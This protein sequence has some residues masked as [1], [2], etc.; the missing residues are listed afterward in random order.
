M[1]SILLA[2]LS[3][4]AS[5][6]TGILEYRQSR[7]IP[8]IAWQSLLKTSGFSVVRDPDELA[9]LFKSGFPDG[10]DR[11]RVNS[12]RTAVILPPESPGEGAGL[13][14]RAQVPRV[15][16]ERWTALPPSLEGFEEFLR[17]AKEWGEAKT[18]SG[19]APP[20]AR[21]PAPGVR[22][23]GPKWID[24]RAFHY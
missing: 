4:D 22:A 21:A 18:L 10:E 9:Q 19:A 14:A 1:I 8:S 24:P 2:A 3:V 6:K 13:W 5:R 15:A 16:E 20:P 17:I 12:T 11:V 23:K 7:V